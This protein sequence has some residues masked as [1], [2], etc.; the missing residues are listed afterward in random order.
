MSTTTAEDKVAVAETVYRYALGVDTR[1]WPL[2]RAQ[3]ADRV[4]VDFTGFAAGMPDTEMAADTWVAGVRPLF[5]RLHATHHLMG[6]P[7]VDV[8]GD[9][10]RITM[11]VQATHVGDPGDPGARYTIGGYYENRL[12]RV[13]ARWL[14]TA[15]KLTVLW[16][17]GDPA[18][19]ES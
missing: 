10:A 5:E 4:H 9:S 14:L 8:D 6:N 3:F 12:A 17:A 15:V 7:I 11:Y 13:D 19:M 18:V 2:Y 16:R 1:D